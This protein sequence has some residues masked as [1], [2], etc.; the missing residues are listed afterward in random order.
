M[1]IAEHLKKAEAFDRALSKLDPMEDSALYVVFLMRACTNRVNAALHA[2]GI[3][4]DGPPADGRVGDLNHTYKPTLPSAPPNVLQEA[5]KQL[6]FIEDLRPDF[7]RGPKPL[8]RDT[9][10][11]CDKAYAEIRRSTERILEG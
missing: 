5:F 11:A 4:T 8:D 2:L 3:T 1:K 9:A 6:K 10:E 7:V